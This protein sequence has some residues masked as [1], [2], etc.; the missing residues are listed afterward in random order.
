MLKLNRTY[1]LDCI[2]GLKQLDDESC[3]C[4]I[5][6][7]PYYA[8]RDYGI[9]PTHWPEVSFRPMAGLPSITIPN[10]IGCLGLEPTPQMFIAHVVLIFREVWR[11]LRNDG[12]LWLNIGDS[13]VGTGGNRKYAVLNPIFNAQ[14][15]SQ[16]KNDRY[17]KIKQLKEDE[18][19]SKDLIGIP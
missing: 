16:P 18:L 13:Y 14:Q 8:L 4:S 11:V 7:P 3:Y 10:W 19:K 6:S 12:T 5:T 9:S 17:K 1:N 15:S 2:S